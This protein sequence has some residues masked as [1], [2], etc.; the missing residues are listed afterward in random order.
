[1]INLMYI[2]LL[3]MLALNVSSDVL[4]GFSLVDESINRT[5]AGSTSENDAIY[6][7]FDEQMKANPVKVKQ[8]FDK[9]RQVRAMS[10]S[11][12]NYANKLKQDIVT[13]ADGEDGDVRNI[14]NKQDLE[15][16]G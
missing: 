11:L 15:E 14:V 7:N 4:N 6:R 5:T 9:A 1:M 2:V 10:D 3:A 8:W 13:Y 12:Y 16:A